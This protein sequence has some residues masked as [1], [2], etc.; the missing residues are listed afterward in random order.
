MSPDEI[1]QNP[2][3]SELSPVQAKV[4]LALTQGNATT[5]AAQSAGVHRST[6][7]EWLRNDPGFA[8]ALRQS[9]REYVQTLR[10][11]MK[12]LSAIALSTLRSLL[13]DPNTPAAVRLRAALAVLER[14]RYPEQG[15]NLPESLNTTRQDEF[16]RNFA[17]LEKDYQ[18]SLMEENLRK[19][20]VE[21]SAEP[22]LEPASEPPAISR[23]ARC[24]C[25][26]GL[27]YKRC[28]GARPAGNVQKVFNAAA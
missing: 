20:A 14:P 7:Y 12:E 26:S 2:P 21:D 4:V 17:L 3:L 23:N 1:R 27:K 13:E 25:G 19:H 15:W 22:A 6:V 8:A 18:V 10:D 28:C 5:Q 24:P 9:R 11:Q 16:L